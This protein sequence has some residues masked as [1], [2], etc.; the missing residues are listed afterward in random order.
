MS[1][2]AIIDT[3]A[4]QSQE[5]LQLL[6]SFSADEIANLRRLLYH[7]ERLKRNGHEEGK[8]PQRPRRF[9]D[10]DDGGPVWELGFIDE[11]DRWSCYENTMDE[12]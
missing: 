9:I 5:V 11:F 3:K 6:L 1:T 4:A 7:A 12:T 8:E 2:Q 10:P